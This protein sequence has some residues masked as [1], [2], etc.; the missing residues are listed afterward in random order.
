MKPIVTATLNPSIDGAA[1]TDRVRHTHKI[2]TTNERYDPGGGGINVARVV[3]ELGGESVAVYAAGGATGGVLDT[4]VGQR[5]IAFERVPIAQDTRIS[6]VVFERESGKE[7]RFVPEG[8]RLSAEECEAFLATIADLDADYVVASGS[9]P[10]GAPEDFYPRLVARARER[11]IAVVLDTSGA[12]L[13][14]AIAHGGLLLVKP[15]SGEFEALVGRPLDGIDAIAREAAALVAAGK[16]EIVAVTMGHEGALLA[17]REG[18]VRR[19]TPEVEVR[20]AVGAGDSF[21]AGMTFALATGKSP[22]EAFVT[23]MAAGTA[24]VLTPGTDLCARPDVERLEAQIAAMT[25]ESL[26]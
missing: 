15:S 19:H 12:A 5:G 21:V 1:E 2:R 4:L 17:T 10:R 9:L 16:A 6:H 23:G 26:A 7:Y 24:A 22:R 25:E 3:R 13:R 11:G 14:A 18:V 20:S 8:P